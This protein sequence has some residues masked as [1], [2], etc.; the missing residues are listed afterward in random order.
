MVLVIA[1]MGV[2]GQAAIINDDFSGTSVDSSVWT[3]SGNA[4]VD[5]S[6]LQV[7]NGGYVQSISSV[8]VLDDTID[9][10][11]SNVGTADWNVYDMS[12]VQAL[13]LCPKLPVPLP[14]VPF[15]PVICL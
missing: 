6:Y 4:T 13:F 11:F 8:S 10:T 9:I 7:N 1:A 12:M 5:S 14:V 3:S 2:A 15:Q